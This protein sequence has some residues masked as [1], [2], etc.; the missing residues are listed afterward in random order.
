MPPFFAYLDSK[1]PKKQK[2]KKLSPYVKWYPRAASKIDKMHLFLWKI[3]QNWILDQFQWF[4]YQTICYLLKFCP[5]FFFSKNDPKCP[6]FGQKTLKNPKFDIWGN[7][8]PFFGKIIKKKKHF[9]LALVFLSI[10]V[11][12]LLKSECNFCHNDYFRFLF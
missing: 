4:W 5:K 6:I 9:F 3:L 10:L 11:Q 2:K 7:F 1:W 12:S 8:W